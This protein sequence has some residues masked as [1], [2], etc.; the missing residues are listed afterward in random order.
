VKVLGLEVKTENIREE[1]AQ[2]AG[3]LRDGVA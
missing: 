2:T 3:K 1:E